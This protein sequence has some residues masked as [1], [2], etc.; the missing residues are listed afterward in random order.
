MAALIDHIGAIEME[1]AQMTRDG[2]WQDPS[3][4][5]ALLKIEAATRDL[6]RVNRGQGL[7]ID[8]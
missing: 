1:I 8:D 5:A 4:A 3:V 7:T 6:H 2:H